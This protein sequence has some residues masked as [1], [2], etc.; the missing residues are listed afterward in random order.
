VAGLRAGPAT[1]SL[2]QPGSPLREPPEDPTRQEW[3]ILPIFWGQPAVHRLG[4]IG[5]IAARLGDEAL[6]HRMAA[7]LREFKTS[8][9]DFDRTYWRAA[10]TVQLGAKDEAMRLFEEAVARESLMVWQADHDVPL[11]LSSCW[12][13][14][15]EAASPCTT[16]S[17]CTPAMGESLRRSSAT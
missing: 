16:G 11:E 13:R 3:D 12:I 7:Q 8:C 14:G 5:S 9:P 6:A 2:A 15:G 1:R 4:W 10:I 17:S